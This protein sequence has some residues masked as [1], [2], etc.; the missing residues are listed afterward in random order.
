MKEIAMF[1]NVLLLEEKGKYYLQ[2]D[3]GMFTIVYKRLAITNDEAKSI[4]QN[5]DLINDIVLG[6]HDRGEYGDMVQ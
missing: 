3:A 1:D 6:Y 4:L 5:P 2:Y